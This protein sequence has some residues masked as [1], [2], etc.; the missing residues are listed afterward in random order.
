MGVT[1]LK[2]RS[3]LEFLVSCPAQ[4]LMIPEK[5]HISYW[6]FHKKPGNV[7][8]LSKKNSQPLSNFLKKPGKVIEI[9]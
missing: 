8:P 6:T 4:K 5:A 1:A 7:I 9:F 3:I 2:E